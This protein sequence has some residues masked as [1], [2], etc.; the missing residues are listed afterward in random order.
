[1]TTVAE[2]LFN[3]FEDGGSEQGDDEQ[4]NDG[5]FADQGYTEDAVANGCATGGNADVGMELE[6]DEEAPEDADLAGGVPSHLKM[7]DAED[8]E[9]TK[10]RVEK[11]QLGGV[12]DVRSVAGLMK[13]LQPVMEVS[14]PAPGAPPS[15]T[16]IYET[17]I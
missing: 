10:A 11:M 6:D 3:D 16:V 13:Q 14:R 12:S 15:P 17:R 2:E 7:D 5:L 9:E 8:E 1:M 4:Q